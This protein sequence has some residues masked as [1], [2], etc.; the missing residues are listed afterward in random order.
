MAERRD[1]EQLARALRALGGRLD[2]PP[3]PDLATTVRARLVAERAFPA[4]EE[5][6]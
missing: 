3:T 5:T 2:Y 4:L 1:D 6:R